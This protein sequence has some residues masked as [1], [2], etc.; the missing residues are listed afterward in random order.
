MHDLHDVVETLV[1]VCWHSGSFL[2]CAAGPFLYIFSHLLRLV[3]QPNIKELV[4][5]NFG[6]C[7]RVFAHKRWPRSRRAS[8][9]R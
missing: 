1:L 8:A 4:L 7:C 2:S 5:L 6:R 3:T 9:Q